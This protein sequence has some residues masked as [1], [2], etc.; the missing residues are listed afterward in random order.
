MKE[1]RFLS[2]NTS[3]FIYKKIGNTTYKVSVHFNDGS[4]ENIEDKIL[5]LA[6]NDAENILQSARICDIMELPQTGRLPERS[7]S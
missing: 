3:T 6:K 5:R 2:K 1:G 7:S 4:K